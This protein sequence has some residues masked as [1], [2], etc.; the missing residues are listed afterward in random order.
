[1][2]QR[3]VS[4]TAR[5]ETF[6]DALVES[7]RYRNAAEVVSEGLRLVEDSENDPAE[8][9]RRL[10]A[11]VQLGIAAIER[12]DYIEFSDADEMVAFLK[13]ESDTVIAKFSES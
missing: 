1:M 6:I 3:N 11:A 12:G 5:Q 4:L 9:L 7:G 2:A 10:R 13:A 8:K